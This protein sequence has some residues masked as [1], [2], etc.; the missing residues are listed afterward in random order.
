MVAVELLKSVISSYGKD[1][2][3]PS[4]ELAIEKNYMWN[5]EI[6]NKR[7]LVNTSVSLFP[8]PTAMTFSE[9]WLYVHSAFQIMHGFLL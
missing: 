6:Q 5:R 9:K 4:A 7:E 1:F 3:V 2:K 8:Y